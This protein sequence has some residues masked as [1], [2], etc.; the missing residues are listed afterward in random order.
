MVEITYN[1]LRLLTLALGADLAYLGT[2]RWQ[3]W[4]RRRDF[5]YRTLM[6]FTEL[7]YDL[8]DRLAELLL[9]PPRTQVN[10]GW[11]AGGSSP[12]WTPRSWRAM[13][14]VHPR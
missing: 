14:G 3:R 4:R 9:D 11:G 12:Q 13:G 2:E 6:K 7:T 8:M 5:Q 1:E 10:P